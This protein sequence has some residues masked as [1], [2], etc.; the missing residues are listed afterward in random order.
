MYKSSILHKCCTEVGIKIHSCEC[1]LKV[2]F[3]IRDPVDF[4]LITFLRHFFS[5]HIVIKSNTGALSNEMIT[6]SKKTDLDTLF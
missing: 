6:P 3:I 4:N 5:I 2:H 1:T